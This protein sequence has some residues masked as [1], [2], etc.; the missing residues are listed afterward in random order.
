MYIYIIILF[1]AVNA[2]I[3]INKTKKQKGEVG[4]YLIRELPT[5]IFLA[6]KKSHSCQ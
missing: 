1:V 6:S 5:Q 2:L 4:S 3:I